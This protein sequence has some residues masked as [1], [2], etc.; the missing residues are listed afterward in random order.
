MIVFRYRCLTLTGTL[1]PYSAGIAGRFKFFYNQI[2]FILKYKSLDTVFYIQILYLKFI[3][4]LLNIK[5][6]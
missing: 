4:L 6:T 3:Y 5:R 2:V 1:L